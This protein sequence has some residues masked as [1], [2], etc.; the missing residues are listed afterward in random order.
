V[1]S[2]ESD[3]ARLESGIR[4]LKVQYDMFF[5]GALPREPLELRA[6]LEQIIRRHSHSTIN[7]YA[8]RFHF[9]ALVSRFNSFCEL[10]GKTTRS[11]EEGDHRSHSSLDKFEIKERL[12]GRCRI[13]ASM[14]DAEGLRRLHSR[15]A[16]ARRRSGAVAPDLAS[17]LRSIDAQMQ[18]LR[19]QSKCGQIELR[20]VL[21]DEKVQ[22]KARPVR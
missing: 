15:Y 18:R 22:I 10:W 4:Q 17:F 21:R 2:V 14:E 20:L 19:Q 6:E 3:I 8:T 13:G 12:L 16:F 1:S 7:K 11:H 9:N 5:A